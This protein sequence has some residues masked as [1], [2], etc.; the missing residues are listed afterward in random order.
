MDRITLNGMRYEGRLGATEEERSV[1]Q[2]VEVDLEVE[3]DLERAAKSDALADTVDYGPLVELT[4]RSVE[5]GSYRLLEALA[6][7]IADGAL[8]LSP[9]IEAVT[10]RVRKLAVP[11]DVDMDYAQVEL[12]RRRDAA[13]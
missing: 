7:A 8:Q 12:V 4:A 9:A 1:P 13:G 11:M 2:L 5:R 3:A 6:G 10:V